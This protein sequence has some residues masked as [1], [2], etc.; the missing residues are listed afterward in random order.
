MPYQKGNPEKGN[1]SDIYS[2]YSNNY[3]Y[4]NTPALKLKEEPII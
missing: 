4:H 3:D 2:K 1:I